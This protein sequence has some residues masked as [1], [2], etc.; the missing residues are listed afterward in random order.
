MKKTYDATVCKALKLRIGE[1]RAAANVEDLLL[2]T[3]RWERLV[4]DRAG[5]WSGRLTKNWRLIVR[6][7]T[8]TVVSVIEIIDY[9]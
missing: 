4:G 5:Q 8:L 2:G 9:H 3:G 7:D 1:L 6:E